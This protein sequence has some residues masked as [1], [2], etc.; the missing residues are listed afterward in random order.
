M[1]A[2]L[3]EAAAAARGHSGSCTWPGSLVSP[4]QDRAA[5]VNHETWRTGALAA[6]P[7][8]ADRRKWDIVTKVN[9][10]SRVSSV[11]MWQTGSIREMKY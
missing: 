7:R 3:L 1:F 11:N 2:P 5:R 6:G 4:R 10:A 9:K 8:T